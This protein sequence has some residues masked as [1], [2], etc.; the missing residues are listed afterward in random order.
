M[1][2]VNVLDSSFADLAIK[3][4]DE[5]PAYDCTIKLPL[6]L[7]E[8]IFMY[9]GCEHA[10]I[11]AMVCRRWDMIVRELWPQTKLKFL[12]P[13]TLIIST[14]S[15][16]EWGC[17]ID[18]DLGSMSHSL[19][20]AA[21]NNKNLFLF[22]EL[23]TKQPI[24]DEEL[25]KLISRAVYT[26][27]LVVLQFLKKRNPLMLEGSLVLAAK[28]G[29]HD[30]VDW[31]LGDGF[32]LGNFEYYEY[33]VYMNR[34]QELL[35][36]LAGDDEHYG[37]TTRRCIEFAARYDRVELVATLLS[38]DIDG[39]SS[40]DISYFILYSTNPV[41]TD[42]II[43]AG[44]GFSNHALVSAALVGN[45]EIFMQ[46]IN[47][48]L[49]TNPID[50]H[51]IG[52]AVLSGNLDILEWVD[53]HT[54]TPSYANILNYSRKF[55]GAMCVDDWESLYLPDK[56]GC[57]KP[58]QMSL[59]ETTNAVEVCRWILDHGWPLHPSMLQAAVAAK[60]Y[61]IAD[62]LVARGVMWNPVD[63]GDDAFIMICTDNAVREVKTLI[64]KYNII[65]NIPAYV[66]E[67]L[68]PHASVEMIVMIVDEFV[69][70][71]WFPRDYSHGNYNS[72]MAEIAGR[73]DMQ[74]VRELH[75]QG[76]ICVDYVLRFAESGTRGFQ[77][78][79]REFSESV[80]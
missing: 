11:L 16:I 70:Q 51:A 32:C 21:I 49:H 63:C 14:P 13:L 60:S 76:I 23:F 57:G 26:G 50:P 5:A 71:T 61:D 17:Q 34:T 37:F 40:L 45:L 53:R 79:I 38:T 35:K 48:P 74:L 43:E 4:D 27:S 10:H 36:V 67:Q 3:V 68:V 73:C 42:M 28:C 41:V 69:N 22:K 39:F 78:K 58:L 30:I 25:T 59:V 18:P 24:V 8:H 77:K 65:L 80:M 46:V 2:G 33:L 56:D 19:L 15:M 20:L 31:L 29:H 62:E 75:E 66:L 64:S 72:C 54:D 1:A 55:R 52:C 44:G 9:L 6:E 12:T 7:M 47:H